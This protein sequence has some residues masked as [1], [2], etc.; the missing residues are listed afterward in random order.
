MNESDILILICEVLGM[1]LPTVQ[2]SVPEGVQYNITSME[3]EDNSVISILAID[4]V[5]LG[6]EGNYVCSGTN[7]VRDVT[8]EAGAFVY[9][10]GDYIHIHVQ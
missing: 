4:S 3:T 5:S 9:I 1:P 7:G 6:D 2:W 8:V 10:Q